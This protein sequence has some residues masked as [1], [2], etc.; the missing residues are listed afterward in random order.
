MRKNMDQLK[1][2]PI[3]QIVRSPYQDREI[4]Q[5]Y[6]NELAKT[7]NET[8]VIQP[9]IVRQLQPEPNAQYELIAGE[10]RW[11]GAGLAGLQTI[12]AVIKIVDDNQASFM[13]LIENLQRK[14]LNPL[15]LAKALERRLYF[16]RTQKE[17]AE[18]VGKS[19][20]WITQKLKILEAP[21]DVQQ[22]IIDGYVNDNAAISALAK[23]DQ[24]TRTNVIKKIRDGNYKLKDL[25]KHRKAKQNKLNGK[26][27]EQDK[28]RDANLVNL[29]NELTDKL[30]AMVCIRHNDNG[31]GDC[32]GTILIT[33]SSLDVLDGILDHI[34]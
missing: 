2:I 4:D 15:Q 6:A 24:K 27:K 29:E 34:Q 3:D 10:H 11:V 14:N 12:P 28:K 7:I 33:Y 17:L 18:H 23:L 19:E 25:K 8:G 26:V 20:A 5:D 31:H 1:N 21:I 9:I 16:F 32:N 22:L 30:G 13:L